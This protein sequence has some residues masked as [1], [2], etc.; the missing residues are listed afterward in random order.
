M[1]KFL[2]IILTTLMITAICGFS[3]G[4][5]NNKQNSNDR[6]NGAEWDDKNWTSNY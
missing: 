2:T 4:C 3:V 5:K 1:K 6:E